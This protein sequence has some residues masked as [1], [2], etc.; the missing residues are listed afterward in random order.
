LWGSAERPVT[1]PLGTKILLSHAKREKGGL[2]NGREEK[3]DQEKGDELAPT[4]GPGEGTRGEFTY[5]SARKRGGY[6]VSPEGA[7]K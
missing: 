7:L 5:G 6:I 2:G 3:A 1:N 4:T